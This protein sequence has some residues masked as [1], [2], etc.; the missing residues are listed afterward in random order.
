LN[1]NVV[2]KQ[3]GKGGISSGFNEQAM[4]PV[5]AS[6]FR[7]RHAC[8]EA[9]AFGKDAPSAV[10]AHESFKAV[11]R[12]AMSVG[13]M[14]RRLA[15]ALV[16]SD[17][18]SEGNEIEKAM[19]HALRQGAAQA[20]STKREQQHPAPRTAAA[21]SGS[22]RPDALQAHAGHAGLR[23]PMLSSAHTRVRMGVS[24]TAL[25]T[26]VRFSTDANPST[27]GRRIKSDETW[28]RPRRTGGRLSVD[29]GRLS[30]DSA[31]QDPDVRGVGRRRS[32]VLPAISTI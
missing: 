7:W 6:R 19:T 30:V 28:T 22:L 21:R 3:G 14:R 32:G 12:A 8:A 9:L 5:L 18:K 2:T 17:V 24:D 4:H 27:L 29:G 15:G 20:A 25:G 11:A 1:G 10:H 13:T 31:Y 26:G 23:P 16:K